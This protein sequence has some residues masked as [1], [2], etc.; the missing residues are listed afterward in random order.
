M[1]E[2]KI[3]ENVPLAKYTTLGI[4]GPARYFVEVLSEKDL[5]GAIAWAREKG[6]EYIVI[7]GGSNLLVSDEGYE[8]LVIRIKFSGIEQQDGAIIVKAGTHL[9]KLVDYTIEH[10]LDGLSTMVG[11]PG[12]VGGAVYGCAGAYGDN[13]RDYIKEI[14]YFDGEKVVTIT[15]DDYVTGYRDSIFKRNKNWII[16]KIKFAG[17]PHT[18]KEGLEREAVEVLERRA[19]KYN[20]GLK[21]PGSFFKNIPEDELSLGQLT[22]VRKLIAEWEHN[23]DYIKRFGNTS[24]VR[25]GKIPAGNLIDMLGGKG[26]QIGQIKINEFHANTFVNLGG[27][28]AKDFISLARK[29]RDKVREEFGLILEPEVQLVGF[30]EDF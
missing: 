26:D 18:D 7:A 21:S 16:L 15:R 30:K 19:Q 11:V 29:W 6:V 5:K 8:G 14:T 27:G 1:S 10:G 17:L 4:G 13:I 22:K 28:D 2:P 23:P 9:Q 3:L 25:F 24:V 12:S 20:S